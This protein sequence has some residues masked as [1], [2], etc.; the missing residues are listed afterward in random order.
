MHPPALGAP[1]TRERLSASPSRR[2]QPT[3]LPQTISTYDNP[4][5]PVQPKAPY[6][7]AQASA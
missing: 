5:E 3:K 4:A 2:C 6:D 7:V 1:W